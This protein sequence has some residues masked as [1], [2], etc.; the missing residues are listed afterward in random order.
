MK[1]DKYASKMKGYSASVR[2]Q[3]ETSNAPCFCTDPRNASE[4]FRTTV[5]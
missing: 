4:L 2:M 1:I 3:V 5:P